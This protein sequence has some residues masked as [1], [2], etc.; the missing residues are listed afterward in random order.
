MPNRSA[1]AGTSGLQS[2]L[3]GFCLFTAFLRKELGCFP[4][5]KSMLHDRR[6]KVGGVTSVLTAGTSQGIM[7]DAPLLG[8]KRDDVTVE[9][10]LRFS[11][12]T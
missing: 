10:R 12:S 4:I 8:A 6:E 1:Q 9:I 3:K 5:E 2:V 11:L 7:G